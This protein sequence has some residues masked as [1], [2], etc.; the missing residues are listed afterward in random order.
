MLFLHQTSSRFG[1]P[2]YDFFGIAT[3]EDFTNSFLIWIVVSE[4][5]IWEMPW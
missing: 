5:C 4:V 1:A 2:F 3:Q